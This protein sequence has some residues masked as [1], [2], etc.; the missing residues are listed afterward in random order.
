MRLTRYGCVQRFTVEPTLYNMHAALE[1]ILYISRVY[2]YIYMY[3]YIL[4]LVDY[5]H[6]HR[7]RQL[8]DP[9][10]PTAFR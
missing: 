8:Y 2:I 9:G 3:M 10:L 4:L 6:P 5:A 7:A 1:Y